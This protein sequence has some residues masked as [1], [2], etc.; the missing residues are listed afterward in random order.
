MRRITYGGAV[1]LDGF[2]AG[3][4]E[5][6]DW[7]FYSP[8]VAQVMRDY[9]KGVDA[10]L[11]GRKT[12]E[13]AVRQQAPKKRSVQSKSTRSKAPSVRTYV[14]SRTLKAIGDGSA[15][16]V[17]TDAAEF[18]RRLKQGP[19]GEICLVG[20]GEFATALFAANLVDRV[21]LNIHPILLGAG[22]P[23]FRDAGHRVQLKLTENRTIAG[24]CIVAYYDVCN[25]S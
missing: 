3:P 21:G 8:D 5:E 2:I 15:E 12:W 18:V 16:L 1:S 4:A 7:L 9:W 19:G 6:I 20:G 14:F 13:F 10:V 17:R 11:M 23:T 22:I 25:A 24:G